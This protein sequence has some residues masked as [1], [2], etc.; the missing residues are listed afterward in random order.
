[1]SVFVPMEARRT[2]KGPDPSCRDSA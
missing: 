2:R 1:M